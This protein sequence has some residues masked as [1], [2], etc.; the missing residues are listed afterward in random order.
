M[1]SFA[2]AGSGQAGEGGDQGGEQ[3]L[4]F[5]TGGEAGFLHGFV[6]EGVGWCDGKKAAGTEGLGGWEIKA[7]NGSQLADPNKPR[8]LKMAPGAR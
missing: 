4:G 5:A 3:P 7:K 1:G 8:E 2:E 6:G